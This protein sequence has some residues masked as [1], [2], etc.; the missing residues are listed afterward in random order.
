M[1]E[2]VPRS[3]YVLLV[4]MTLATLGGPLTFGIVLRGGARA[5]WPPDRAVEW[6]MLA[7]TSGLVLMLMGCCFWLGWSNLK[8]LK[9][10]KNM[11][12]VPGPS[13]KAAP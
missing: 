4:L 6:V 3:P 7:A 2:P 12:T 5:D 11:P 10:A 8:D 1:A 13:D 9:R